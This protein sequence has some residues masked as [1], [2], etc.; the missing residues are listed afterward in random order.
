LKYTPPG[1]AIALTVRHEGERIRLDVTDTGIGIDH[2]HLP[3]I[4]EPFFRADTSRSR[5]TGGA[6]LGLAISAR[7]ADNHHA[8]IDVDSAPD[9]GTTISVL[10]PRQPAYQP[11]ICAG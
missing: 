8:S 6:G 7:I 9:R 2:A 10:L 1:G 4:F 3:R 5:E 11:P